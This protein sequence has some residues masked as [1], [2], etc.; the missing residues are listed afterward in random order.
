[1]PAF[2][3]TIFVNGASTAY[4]A[5][6]G[7]QLLAKRRRTRLE[8]LLGGIFVYW[9]L[10]TAK[11]LVSLLPGSYTAT[12]L[13][14]IQMIDGWS[15]ITLACASLRAYHAGVGDLEAR[16]AARAALCGLHGRI[17][18][19]AQPRHGHRLPG[20]SSPFFG[21]TVI[22]IGYAK[23]E[24][25]TH[26]LYQNY[27]DIDHMDISWLRKIY[28]AGFVYMTL[29]VVVSVVRQPAVD[30]LLYLAGIAFWQMTLYYC[31]GLQP[32]RPEPGGADADDGDFGGRRYYQFA[33]IVESIVEG[34]A[35]YLD[36]KLSLLQLASR[37][38]TNRTYLSNYF[39]AVK[40]TTFYDYVNAL[41]I[42]KESVPMM[43]EHP[44]YALDYVA[45]QSGFNSLSTFRR[46]FR[47][48]TGMT[49]G[50]FLSQNGF[51]ESSCAV[52]PAP[53]GTGGNKP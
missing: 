10:A 43:Q 12:V 40:N 49:P 6:V 24:V 5:V 28:A 15:V 37:L 14:A 21:A 7:S 51:G 29:W 36:P 31:S 39:N 45:Q 30:S 50:G 23:A 19:A 22:R 8:T 34:E 11:D 52:E 44:E 1:M 20:A 2:S 33:G 4:F 27:S 3:L 25:Y 26:Y 48:Y 47:K 32:V 38:G 42:E 13:D 18:R 41:R 46:A 9:A 35:L 53:D 17:R 16:G